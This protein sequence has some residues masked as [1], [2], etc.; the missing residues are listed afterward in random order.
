MPVDRRQFLS[1]VTLTAA[2]LKFLP[3]TWALATENPTK[4][5]GAAAKVYGS[6]YFGNWIRTNSACPRSTTPATR[7]TIPKR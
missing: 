6:G 1:G 3:E 5:G 7:S 2:G 4:S